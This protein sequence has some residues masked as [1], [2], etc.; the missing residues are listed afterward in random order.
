[1]KDKTTSFR[2]ATDLLEKVQVV[3]KENDRS[4]RAEIESVLRERFHAKTK[5]KGQ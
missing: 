2:I 4:V 3:A 5:G 1:M